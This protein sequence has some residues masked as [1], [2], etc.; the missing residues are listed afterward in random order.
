MQKWEY[1]AVIIYLTRNL[2]TVNDVETQI[3]FEGPFSVHVV[4]NKLGI[5]GWEMVGSE[6][7]L[8]GPGPSAFFFKRPLKP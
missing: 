8:A 4:L 2:Y 6:L 1:A 5:D 3:E 7:A